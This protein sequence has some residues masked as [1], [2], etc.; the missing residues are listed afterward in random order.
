MAEKQKVNSA[1][2]YLNDM[3]DALF[4]GW[5]RLRTAFNWQEFANDFRD[6]FGERLMTDVIEEFN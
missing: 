6:R 3:A 4:Q 1:A 2:A 5:S